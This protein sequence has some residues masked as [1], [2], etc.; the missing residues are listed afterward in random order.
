MK[1]QPSHRDI[2]YDR[3]EYQDLLDRIAASVRR[4]RE[5]RGWTQ[6]EAARR[7]LDLAMP[8]YA[9]IERAENNATAVTLAR[10]AIGFGVDIQQLLA[11]STAP[12]ARKPG[13]PRRAVRAVE[14]APST[15]EAPTDE[16]PGAV[17]RSAH[18]D[19][20]ASVAAI[21]TPSPPKD[22]RRGRQ[23]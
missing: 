18:G 2:F 13:R 19:A 14:G 1:R 21:A 7:C 17:Q 20:V 12:L 9:S 5:E 23:P 11:P 4:L 3:P 22:A 6:K 8:V 16:A 15:N 10:L